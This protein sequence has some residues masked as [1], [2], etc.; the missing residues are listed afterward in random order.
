VKGSLKGAVPLGRGNLLANL[1]RK[2]VVSGTIATCRVV[3]MRIGRGHA[4]IPPL[5]VVFLDEEEPSHI[6]KS[7][8]TLY[9]YLF[10]T[11]SALLQ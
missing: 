5:G 11:Y 1:S 3:A 4:A 9:S 10:P 8:N 7:S 6:M 2:Q